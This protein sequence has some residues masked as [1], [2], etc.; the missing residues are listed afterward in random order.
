MKKMIVRI[1]KSVTI[2]LKA[3]I[4]AFKMSFR[5]GEPID[6]ILGYTDDLTRLPNRRALQRDMVNIGKPYSLIMID[7]DNFKA[8]NDA[9]GHIF[10]DII[11]RR[12]AELL[13]KTVGAWGTTY[14]IGGDE[15]MA[16]VPTTQVASICESIRSQFRKE[17]SFT[18][19][20][21]VVECFNPAMTHD[22]LELADKAMYMS[23][24]QGKDRITFFNPQ[25]TF[26]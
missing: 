8:I 11:L 13:R 2:A 20:Q 4:F 5:Y 18:I 19:S 24:A 6:S 26:P 10:G 21:G 25:P 22:F 9:N 17:D 15:F 12:L 3:A 14:R 7:I 23:K 16:I 1:A